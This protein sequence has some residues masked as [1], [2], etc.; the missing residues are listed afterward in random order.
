MSEVTVFRTWDEPI[1]D[2]ALDI[3]RSEGINAIK[4]SDVPRSILPTT[5]DGIAEIEMK[6]PR[7]SVEK[8]VEIIE[9]R[10]SQTDINS[11]ETGDIED[12]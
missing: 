12:K 6:V 10:F 5:M 1:A 11:D 4:R 2:M 7:D 9:V 3:L 8:A